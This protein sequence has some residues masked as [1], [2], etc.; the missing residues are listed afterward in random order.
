MYR[1]GLKLLNKIQTKQQNT[2]PQDIQRKSNFCPS[3]RKKINHSNVGMMGDAKKDKAEEMA[4]GNGSHQPTSDLR[5]KCVA[6]V[7]VVVP[8]STFVASLAGDLPAAHL[9][10]K[11]AMTL[12]HV[13]PC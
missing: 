2:Y 1:P 7:H 4:S 10:E 5:E 13:L 12:R 8:W 9:D 3:Q 11:K 6:D